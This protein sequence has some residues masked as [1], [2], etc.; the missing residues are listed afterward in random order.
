MEFCFATEGMKIDLF[1]LDC[2]CL[3]EWIMYASVY[4]LS[5]YGA[6]K[7]C[8]IPPSNGPS[9]RIMSQGLLLECIALTFQ[10]DHVCTE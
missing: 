10:L 1:H 5:I 8:G 6:S 2:V 9:N 3:S 4:K 7:I